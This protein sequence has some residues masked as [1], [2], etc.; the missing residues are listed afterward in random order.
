MKY[1][2]KLCGADRL[3]G[4]CNKVLQNIAVCA[5]QNCLFLTEWREVVIYYSKLCGADRV[6]GGC[7][8]VLQYMAVCVSQF[9]VVLTE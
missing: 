1:C 5:S 3:K 4:G 7:N 9:S 8:K 2:S 6:K